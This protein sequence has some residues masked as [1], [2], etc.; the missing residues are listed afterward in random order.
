MIEFRFVSPLAIFTAT[1]RQTA[2]ALGLSEKTLSFWVQGQTS[3]L[4]TV[5]VKP[6]PETNTEFRFITAQGHRV[7]GL[8]RE[9]LAFLLRALS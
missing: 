8:S 2:V 6:V 5:S 3:K 7:E 4:R 1:L 9:D